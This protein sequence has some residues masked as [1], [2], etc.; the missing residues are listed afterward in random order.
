[1]QW[2]LNGADL[3]GETNT[4]LTITNVQPS[5]A[6]VYRVI[7][8]IPD[9]Q[10][11]S[12]S[13]TLTLLFR[14]VE[15]SV[16]EGPGGVTKSPSKEHYD[17]GEEVTLAASPARWHRFERWDDGS[18]EN[19]RIITVASNGNQFAAYFAPTTILETGTINGVTRT[20]PKG[21]PI[22]L[23]NDQFITDAAV[24]NAGPA[25]VVLQTTLAN[26]SFF[27][28]ATARDQICYPVGCTPAPSKYGVPQQSGPW[29]IHPIFRSR[30]KATRWI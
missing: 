13:A 24:T 26:E 17:I 23:V 27:S 9:D 25:E 6:G 11:P 29:H 5:N 8:T 20:A 22:I 28:A 1:M 10:F 19:P 4:T 3:T 7:V 12:H 30:S 16:A 18:T 15:V 14:T 21:M 2:Q